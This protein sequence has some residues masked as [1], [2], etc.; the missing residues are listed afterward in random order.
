MKSQGVEVHLCH[1]RKLDHIP[2]QENGHIT[3]STC[4][5]LRQGF[6]EWL[7]EQ[8][9]FIPGNLTMAHEWK[10]SLATPA[11]QQERMQEE[12]ARREEEL[13]MLVMGQLAVVLSNT[14][15]TGKIHNQ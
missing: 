1:G 6:L 15:R 12:I 5:F 14:K 13:V 3:A 11:Y 2:M 10:C 4:L 7:D 9:V 8:I